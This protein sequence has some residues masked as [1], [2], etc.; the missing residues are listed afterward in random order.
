MISV[1]TSRTPDRF[2]LE[3]PPR[4][5]GEEEGERER[6]GK[7]REIQRVTKSKRNREKGTIGTYELVLTNSWFLELTPGSCL[8]MNQTF[9]HY[10]YFKGRLFIVD[11]ALSL[12]KCLIIS[13]VYVESLIQNISN[14]I[15]FFVTLVGH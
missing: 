13:S 14:T 15:R 1:G 8:T 4:K 3:T 2:T 11:F 5:E 6:R 7:S 12:A 10:N 9:I